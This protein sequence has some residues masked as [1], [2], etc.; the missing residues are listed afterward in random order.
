MQNDRNPC[1]ESCTNASPQTPKTPCLTTDMVGIQNLHPSNPNAKQK[2][3]ITHYTNPPQTTLPASS[4]LASEALADPTPPKLFF[5]LEVSVLPILVASSS[6]P[7]LTP[8]VSSRCLRVMYPGGVHL[9][10]VQ[11]LTLGSAYMR[12]TC[13]R[14]RVRDSYRKN[15]TSRAAAMLQPTKTKP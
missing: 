1:W 13:S 2:E 5:S 8:L 11:G 10:D 4:T 12:S 15:Q 14:L 7:L 3:S 6:I 9:D